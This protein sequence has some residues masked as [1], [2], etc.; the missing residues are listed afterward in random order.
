MSNIYEIIL[1]RAEEAKKVII[2]GA[3]EKGKEVLALLVSHSIKVYAFFDNNSALTEG[4]KKNISGVTI[5]SPHKVSESNC[6]YIIAVKNP[7]FRRELRIQLQELGIDMNDIIAIHCGRSYEYMSKLDEKYYQEEIQ[8]MYFERFGK[9]INWDNP[10]TYNEKINWE[11]L[12]IKDRRR[13]K[14]VDKYLV[15]DWVKEQIG[16][17]H[18]TQLY[19]VWNDAYDIDFKSLPNKFVLKVNNGSERNIIVKDKTQINEKEICDKL[20]DWMHNNFAYINLE[21]QYKNIIPKIICEEYLEGVA[22]DVYE[23]DVYCFHGKPMYIW[24]IKGSHKPDC[25][26][27]FYNLEWEMMPFSFFYPKDN[28]LAPRPERLEKMLELT[29]ILCKD[30]QHVRVDWFNLPD[31]RILFGEM[32][33]SSCAGIA[34]WTPEEYDTYFGNMI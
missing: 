7:E 9:Y 17:K 3:G 20:N 30:F 26:A 33:F 4:K 16:K 12:N 32:T 5:V 28:I 1:K 14:L 34:H 21:L 8:T 27:S 11:K 22:E 25:K 15:R 2:V 19:G 18:L 23:Y 29:S 13:E 24:C 10:V 31:G 6:L